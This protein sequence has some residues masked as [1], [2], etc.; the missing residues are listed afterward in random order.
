MRI[1]SGLHPSKYF[2]YAELS[3]VIAQDIHTSVL[4]FDD[5]EILTVYCQQATRDIQTCHLKQLKHR[6]NASRYH[7]ML[8]SFSSVSKFKFPL[9]NNSFSL[10][11]I[12]VVRFGWDEETFFVFCFPLCASP[13]LRSTFFDRLKNPAGFRLFNPLGIAF[14]FFSGREFPR[15]SSGNEKNILS[16]GY[17]YIQKLIHYS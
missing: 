4:S 5:F 10:T 15:L 14:G 8:W 16:Y 9:D 7:F 6:V 17:A 12:S 1:N 13:L 11:F 3:F 2:L